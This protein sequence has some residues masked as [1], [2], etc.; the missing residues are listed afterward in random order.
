LAHV[1]VAAGEGLAK[2]KEKEKEKENTL[3]ERD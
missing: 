1:I 3:E 2:Q